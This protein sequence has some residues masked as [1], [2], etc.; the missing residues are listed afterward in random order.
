MVPVSH[1]KRSVD[2]VVGWLRVSKLSILSHGAN[3]AVRDI[4]L[5]WDINAVSLSYN[6]Q[7]LCM[8]MTRPPVPYM[9]ALKLSTNE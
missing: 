9:F 7:A 6:I 3:V 2:L 1:L 8:E 5:E 4:P